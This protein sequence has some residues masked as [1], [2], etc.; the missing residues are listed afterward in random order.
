MY[1]I[2]IKNGTIIDG[3]LSEPKIGFIGIKGKKIFNVSETP[4]FGRIEIDATG[5]IVAPGFIDMHSHS[6]AI[7][8]I[9]NRMESKVFQGVTTE[10]VGNCG[11]SIVPVSSQFQEVHEKF[12]GPALAKSVSE[13]IDFSKLRDTENYLKEL[14]KNKVTTN[15]ISLIGHGTLRTSVMGFSS[16]EATVEEMDKM[17]IRLKKE[18]E[19]GAWGMSLGLLYPPGSFAT[20]SELVELCHVLK[21]YDAILTVH[22]RSEADYIFE[23][24]EEMLEI[25]K[26]TKVHV[27]ISHLKLMGINQHGKAKKLL[28]KISEANQL[29]SVKIT[30]DQYPYIASSTNLL[31]VLPHEVMDGGMGNLIKKLKEDKTMLEILKKGIDSRG[32]PE[33]VQIVRT[34]DELSSYDGK[35]LKEISDFTKKDYSQIAKECLLATRGGVSCVFYSIS[36]L[37]MLEIMKEEE[38]AIASD[39]YAFP[40]DGKEVF[41]IP[42]PRSF[43]TFPRFIKI[44]KE[45]NLMSLEKAIYK[46][47]ALPSKILNLKNKGIIINGFDADLVIFDLD[48][49]ED[50]ATF[51]SP[52]EKPNGIEY[53]INNGEIIVKSGIQTMERPGKLIKNWEVKKWANTHF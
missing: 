26:L 44:C 25:A 11:Q 39:G 6:D 48:L 23:A 35:T 37:D 28:N 7:A 50:K 10:I 12:I 46:I 41:G 53:V 38:I 8:F 2:V 5:K 34:N 13:D 52:Y 18:L 22:L 43:G 15:I 51:S 29:N 30:C 47:T 17:K 3:M 32:G 14:K 36:E 1:D 49:I 45:K 20:K 31:A 4:I 16:R 33:K 9:D 24:I 42:H 27:H 40:I 21:K 19:M